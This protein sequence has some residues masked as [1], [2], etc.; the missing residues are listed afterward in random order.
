MTYPDRRFWTA[1]LAA[2]MSAAVAVALSGCGTAGTDT[3]P[4]RPQAGADD[5]DHTGH[6]HGE[7]E[8]AEHAEHGEEHA[9]DD[10]MQSTPT[11]FA[12]GVGA[13]RQRYEAIRDAFQAD[14]VEKAHEPLHE[15]GGL[16]DALPKLVDQSELSDS[17]KATAKAAVTAMFDAYGQIDGAIH[18]GKAPDYDAVAADL[19]KAMADLDQVLEATKPS[20]EPPSSS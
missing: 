13:L 12:A 2:A 3:D 20:D 1:A 9:G 6:D 14:D 16:L 10:H 4:S 7:G 17:D 8:H 15:V 5:H 11:D 18:D 19:D